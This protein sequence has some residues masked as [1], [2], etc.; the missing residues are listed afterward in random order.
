MVIPNWMSA[1]ECRAWFSRKLARVS[2]SRRRADRSRERFQHR[3]PAMLIESLERRQLLA[4]QA[5][6]MLAIP[7]QVTGLSTHAGS[8][9]GGNPIT[10]TGS[11]FNS[12][13]AVMFDTTLVTSY[14][15]NS[16]SSITVTTPAHA[17]GTVDV[18]VVTMLA[19]VSSPSA[20]RRQN[21][22]YRV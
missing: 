16:S 11:G 2:A 18:T 7:P 1:L 19:P 17:A 15:V 13:S 14:S 12:V 9:L 6:Q 20:T 21:R 5:A 8:T 4:A 10:I 3:S 22:S